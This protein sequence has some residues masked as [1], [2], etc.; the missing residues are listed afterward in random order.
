MLAEFA[1]TQR[2]PDHPEDPA[3]ALRVLRVAMDA[4]FTFLT[5]DA[6]VQAV[7]AQI[8]LMIAQGRY[9]SLYDSV[10]DIACE[11][12]KN[13]DF[14]GIESFDRALRNTGVA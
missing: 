1:A 3:E 2:D 7:N 6:T 14:A 8:A 9:D 11:G 4:A 13:G 12:V 5:D 10:M